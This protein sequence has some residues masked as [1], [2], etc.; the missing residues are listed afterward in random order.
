[1]QTLLPPEVLALLRPRGRAV[2]TPIRTEDASDLDS[3][4]DAAG[5]I[6]THVEIRDYATAAEITEPPR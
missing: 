2:A 6:D 1:T 4:K 5:V 3:E